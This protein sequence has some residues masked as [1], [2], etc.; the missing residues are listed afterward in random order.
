MDLLRQWALFLVIGSLAATFAIVL[1]PGG[2]TDKAMR[3]VAGIFVVALVCTPLKNLGNAES[4]L[5][6]FKSFDDFDD[7]TQSNELNEYLI[8]VCRNAVEKE[9]SET[10]KEL[11]IKAVCAEIEMETDDESCIIIHNITVEIESAHHDDKNRFSDSLSE[12]LGVPVTVAVTG[13]PDL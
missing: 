3:A 1:S 8:S 10:A 13:E 9:V 4:F 5:Q 12:K 7:E 11:G 2:A 6:T